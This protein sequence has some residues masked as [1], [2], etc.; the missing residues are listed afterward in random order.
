MLL[1]FGRGGEKREKRYLLARN[2]DKTRI[3]CTAMHSFRLATV[4]AR[5][6]VHWV[7]HAANVL[8]LRASSRARL[9]TTK[10]WRQSPSSQSSGMGFWV[11]SSPKRFLHATR[12]LE[13]LSSGEKRAGWADSVGIRAN[14]EIV[15]FR[16]S[17]GAEGS[18]DW[19]T[20]THAQ[21]RQAVM[22]MSEAQRPMEVD[23]RRLTAQQ[24]AAEERKY[25]EF[26]D[27][28]K[29]LGPFFK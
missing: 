29:K 9:W 8:S 22:A 3:D 23:C 5:D 17:C 27:I 15:R 28:F 7:F 25:L 6:D 19:R 10:S 24:A 13:N 14:D 18:L 11:G 12:C 16:G 20:N 4:T 2:I 26:L 1:T 21:L